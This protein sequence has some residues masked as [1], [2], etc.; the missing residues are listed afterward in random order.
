M[1]SAWQALSRS[2]R[3]VGI[4]EC[5]G[6]PTL[7]RRADVIVSEDGVEHPVLRPVVAVCTCEKSQRLPWCDS[8][9]KAIRRRVRPS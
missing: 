3:D 9:H 1:S 8:T 7:V 6:G 5:P 4:Q 2:G